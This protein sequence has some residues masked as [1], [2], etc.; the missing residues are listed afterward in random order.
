MEDMILQSKT[1]N[2]NGEVMVTKKVWEEEKF[3]SEQKHPNRIAI[4]THNRL[5]KSENFL[6]HNRHIAINYISKDVLEE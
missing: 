1:G 3:E 4:L 6:N 2:I 5:P